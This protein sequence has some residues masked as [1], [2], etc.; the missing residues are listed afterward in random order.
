MK[1]SCSF[2]VPVVSELR[3]RHGLEYEQSRQR[4]HESIKREQFIRLN[5]CEYLDNLNSKQF[6]TQT[7]VQSAGSGTPPQNALMIT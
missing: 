6:S 7:L 3:Q 1:T 5:V 2:R 4:T